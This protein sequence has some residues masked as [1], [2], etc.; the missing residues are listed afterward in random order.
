MGT[1]SGFVSNS[2]TTLIYDINERPEFSTSQR[3]LTDDFRSLIVLPLIS[4]DQAIGILAVFSNQNNSFGPREQAILERLA[5]QIAPAVENA[6]LYTQLRSR[7]EEMVVV[8]EVA[9]IITSTLDIDEVYEQFAAAIKKLIDFD[10]IEINIIDL[11]SYTLQLAYVTAAG[12]RNFAVGEALPLENSASAFVANSR[13]PLVMDDVNEHPEFWPSRHVLAYGFRSEIIL[14][15]I[16][17]D[18]VIGDLV[19]YSSR[20]NS[21]GRREQTILERLAN[22][23]APAVENAQLYTQLRSHAEEMVV[24]DEVAHIITSTLDIDEV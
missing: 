12:P 22:Q 21:F 20:I 17:K 11:D 7:A 24:V 13:T 15:L 14:P 6:R 1:T 5:K 4:K 9:R 3:D 18:R 8:D 2:G 19:V 23:I 16:S 10:R